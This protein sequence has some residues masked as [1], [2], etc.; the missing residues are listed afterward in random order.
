MEIEISKHALE[1]LRERF[2]IK[3]RAARRHVTRAFTEGLTPEQYG[4]KIVSEHY[5]KRQQMT[6]KF[7]YLI[8]NG[9][10]H[11]FTLNDKGHPVLITA[12]DPLTHEEPE[13]IYLRG[14]KTIKKGG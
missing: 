13:A 14:K 11:I 4:L 5:A 6:E 3:K 12:Y 1:R 9:W 8:Y 2:G 7:M 10:V